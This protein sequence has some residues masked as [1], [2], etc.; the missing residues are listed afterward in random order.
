M[1]F[2]DLGW[3]PSRLWWQRCFSPPAL[4]ALPAAAPP[5]VALPAAARAPQRCLNGTADVGIRILGWINGCSGRQNMIQSC[6]F[7]HIWPIKKGWHWPMVTHHG[8]TSETLGDP[9]CS[10]GVSRRAW[11]SESTWDFFQLEIH[12]N[13]C[14]HSDLTI[15][16]LALECCWLFNMRLVFTVRVPQGQLGKSPVSWSP[17]LV[18]YHGTQLSSDFPKVFF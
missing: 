2:P 10:R 11:K 5:A 3:F 14:Q 12:V 17:W 8:V 1:I 4:R 16:Y 15:R 6:T 7:G 18:V 13:N 9:K